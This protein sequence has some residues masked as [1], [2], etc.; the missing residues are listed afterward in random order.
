[1]LRTIAE[2]KLSELTSLHLGGPALAMLEI[3]SLRDAEDVP[4]QLERIGGRSCEVRPLGGGS[5]ILAQD[6]PLP[7]VLLTCAEAFEPEVR[8]AG[9]GGDAGDAV[10][11]RVSAGTGLP[12][13]V[14][15]C[16]HLG[17]SGMEGLAGV[18]GTVGGAIAG[19]AGARG[20]EMGLVLRQITVFSPEKG[21]HT[22]GRESFRAEYR[23]FS[24]LEEVAG[25]FVI[26]EAEL[27]L[28]RSTPAAV[29]AVIR[30]NIALKLKSQPLQV[31][32]AGCLF[33]NPSPEESPYPAGKLLD[34]AGFRGMRRGGMCF[35]QKHANFLVN[36]G[37]GSATAALELLEEARETVRQKFGVLLEPEVKIWQF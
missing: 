22:L 29:R 16:G 18:P 37:N 34:M 7:A 20:Q 15:L 31:F 6:G 2:P 32:S 8:D 4:G 26:L 13:L 21:V 1:M 12:E 28:Q 14:S 30:E 3:G 24:L 10:R 9:N 36:E 19:N 33:R 11:V 25:Y 5:N 23:R 35:S 27:E 17:L